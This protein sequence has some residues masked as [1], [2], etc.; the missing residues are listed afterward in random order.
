MRD[1]EG[2]EIEYLRI[3]V[4]DRCNLRC[5]YC[6]PEEGVENACHP[7]ILTYEEII[8]VCSVFAKHGLKH[9]K[10][11]GGEPLVRRGVV[12]LIA[13]LKAIQGIESVTL[14]TNGVLLEMYYDELVEAGIDA[15]TVS[16]DTLDSETFQK[17]T[18]RDELEAVLRGVKKATE[19]GKVHFKINCVPM[20]G[21]N[22]QDIL[23][24]VLLA[25]NQD[26]DVRFIE[27][28]PIGYGK[29]F[30]YV[31]EK[32]LRDWIEKAYGPMTKCF[33]KRGNGPAAYYNLQG[34]QGKVGMISAVSHAF[35]H[36]CNRV[37][38]TAEGYLKTCLQYDCGVD[39]KEL[40]RRDTD[41]E[42]LWTAMEAAIR[43]K[44]KAHHFKENERTKD[45][46]LRGMSQIGG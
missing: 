8:R 39:L 30:E 35:C 4:T 25:K 22:T 6:M 44:P 36:E 24:L 38:M 12:H 1:N 32:E 2:R 9:I 14:T 20:R 19:A 27:M 15:I 11:T 7:S 31:S 45:D 5:V 41:D 46:E 13:C 16:L 21:L 33:E 40:L 18:R 23:E 34:F 42:C 17:I 28:M 10:I 26:V 3:S 43:Q 29:Q 37:R